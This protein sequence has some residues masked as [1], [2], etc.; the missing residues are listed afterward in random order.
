MLRFYQIPCE[1]GRIH[2]VTKPQ[3][4]SEL[5]CECGRTVS[6]PTLREIDDFPIVERAETRKEAL[7]LHSHSGTRQKR[8]GLLFLFFVGFLLFGGLSFYFFQ[9]CP[10]EPTVAGAES[11]YDVWQVWQS[12]RTGIDTPPSRG[13]IMRTEAIK[14][15]WRWIIICGMLSVTCLLGMFASTVMKVRH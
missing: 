2:E 7:S 15:S 13:E 3:A 5:T 6:V 14:M 9:T 11:P 1:C 10:K 4:G 8:G 12:L